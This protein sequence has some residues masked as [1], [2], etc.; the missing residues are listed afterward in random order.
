MSILL[1]TH[2][3][4]A[5]AANSTRLSRQEVDFLASYPGRFVIS[6]VSIWE[7]RLKWT[8]LYPSGQR[9]GPV[10]PAQALRVVATQNIDFLAL[11]PTHAAVHLTDP[12]PHR[13]PFDE[14]LL[15]QTQCENL[16]LLTRDRL[17]A[18]H[19]LTMHA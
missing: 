3:V 9:K 1:D 19:P 8:A 7:M 11:T 18:G 13:D 17:L 6:A 14:L 2:Y 10:D 15:A 5:L 12:I 4:Y 16:R